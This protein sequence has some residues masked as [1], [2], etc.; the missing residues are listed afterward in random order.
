MP[1]YQHRVQFYETDLMG[2]IHHSNYLRIFEEARVAWAHTRGMLNY[3]SKESASHLAVLETRVRHL[4]PGKFGD[5][6]NVEVQAHLAKIKIIF[7]YKMWRGEEL[8]A[9][10]RTEHVSLD[11]DLKLIRPP[12]ALKK[13]LE[14]EL[15]TETWLSSL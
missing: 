13:I 12:V 8:L 7:E 4:K 15:W 11:L 6:L 3:Q 14:K 5:L 1:Q 10:A 9:E 2:I